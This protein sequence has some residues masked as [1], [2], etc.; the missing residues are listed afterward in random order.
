MQQDSDLIVVGSGAGGATLAHACARAGKRVLLLE[1][2]RKSAADSAA[3]EQ[4]TLIDIPGRRH[5]RR[6]I[7]L[8]G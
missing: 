1:R 5:D 4:A 6:R 3:N 2:G 7:R 8:T